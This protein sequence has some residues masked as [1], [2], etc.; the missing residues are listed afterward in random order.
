MTAS[1]V[2]LVFALWFGASV[3]NQFDA[4]GYGPA[5][6]VAFL[7]RSLDFFSLIP[8]WNFFAPNP[9]TNDYHLLY[10]EQLDETTYG[11]WREVPFPKQSG[12][13]RLL[14]NPR[15][16]RGKVLSDVVVSLGRAVAAAR[17][18]AVEQL[19][20]AVAETREYEAELTRLISDELQPLKLSIPYL[21]ILNYLNGLPHSPFG[22]SIQFLF[23]QTEGFDPRAEP[24]ILYVSELHDLAS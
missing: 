4:T 3:L 13:L 6:R 10:R 14:W 20:R 9:G 7:L 19:P 18:T 2:V 5:R 15:K 21:I 1:C 8:S 17:E 16:R 12:L 22:R 23:A 11:V 24:D